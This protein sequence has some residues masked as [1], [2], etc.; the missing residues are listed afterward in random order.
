MYSLFGP[1]CFPL[2]PHAT[3]PGPCVHTQ[4]ARPHTAPP[5][6]NQRAP[7]PLVAHDTLPATTN[8]LPLLL[9]TIVP[10][11]ALVPSVSVPPQTNWTP[12]VSCP[13]GHHALA[14]PIRHRALR[15]VASLGSRKHLHRAG[16]TLSRHDASLDSRTTPLLTLNSHAASLS[17]DATHRGSG[18]TGHD[19]R[20]VT[21]LNLWAMHP[22]LRANRQATHPHRPTT[23]AFG[24]RIAQPSWRAA[25]S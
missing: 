23:P 10:F 18:T 1:L 22:G 14:G 19:S 13:A 9:M 5:L 24:L 3:R 4:P 12:S 8:A 15:L 11:Q 21:D 25:Q 6:L 2:S 17:P 20:A 7:M 16:P